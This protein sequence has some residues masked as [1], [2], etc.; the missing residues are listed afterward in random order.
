MLNI[1][2]KSEL[3]KHISKDSNFLLP[4]FNCLAHTLFSI[5]YFKSDW[6]TLELI[7]LSNVQSNLD[8]LRFTLL[9]IAQC[10]FPSKLECTACRLE[11]VNDTDQFKASL[12]VFSKHHLQFGQ[13]SLLIFLQSIVVVG[14]ND[15]ND[16]AHDQ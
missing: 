9:L 13:A 5:T 12:T 6:S 14:Q 2:T 7:F 16:A 15:N 4:S 10:E 11:L 1:I 8:C 3:G